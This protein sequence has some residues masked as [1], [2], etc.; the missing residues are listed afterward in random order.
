ML[1]FLLQEREIGTDFLNLSPEQ[2]TIF[3]FDNGLPDTL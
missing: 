1:F 2:V 3:L